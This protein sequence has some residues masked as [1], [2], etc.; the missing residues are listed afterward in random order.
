MSNSPDASPMEQHFF[1]A[2]CQAL[3]VSTANADRLIDCMRAAMLLSAY[4]Y[5]SG[6]YHEVIRNDIPLR[7]ALTLGMGVWRCGDQI[8]IV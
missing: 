7:A 1:M 3:D 8:D 5:T 2:S 4:S 6:R